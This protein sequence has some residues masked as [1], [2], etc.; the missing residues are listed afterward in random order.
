MDKPRPTISTQTIAYIAQT[1][2]KG[3]H[4]LKKGLADGTLI[5]KQLDAID[6]LPSGKVDKRS[7]VDGHVTE[8]DNSTGRKRIAEFPEMCC[9]DAVATLGIIYTMAGVK[10]EDIIEVTAIPGKRN[11]AFN[12]HKWLSVQGV[13][14][15]LTLG[16]FHP[17]GENVGSTVAFKTHPFEGDEKY[18]IK[19]AQF[20]SPT[21]IVK[22]AEFM[23][24][25]Y[26]FK[27]EP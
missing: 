12:F 9:A 8:Q 23:G 14:I 11:P 4:D 5:D 17:L 10:P 1:I 27:N 6:S 13:R 19:K 7:P 25:S 20:I 26:I 16:Q 18:R 15:D 2:S 3:F 21:P 22:F 24:F